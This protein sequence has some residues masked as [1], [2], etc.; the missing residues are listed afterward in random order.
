MRRLQISIPDWLRKDKEFI[1]TA[2]PDPEVQ[3]AIRRYKEHF[4]K[5][6]IGAVN[7]FYSFNDVEGFKLRLGGRTSPKFSKLFRA[8]GHVL[9]GFKDEQLKYA[10][11]LTW[12]LNGKP[13]DEF[14]QNKLRL[15]YQYETNFPGMEMQMVNEDNFLLSFKRTS[16]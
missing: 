10:G 5:F 9:Y 13:I 16:W 8:D 12:S 2:P 15:F 11:R 7:T 6:D 14:P 3:K 4:G 1:P